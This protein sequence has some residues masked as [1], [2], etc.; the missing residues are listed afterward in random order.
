MFS[1]PW[2]MEW[3]YFNFP[4]TLRPPYLAKKPFFADQG[5][6]NRGFE[7]SGC[8]VMDPRREKNILLNMSSRRGRERKGCV[9]CGRLRGFFVFSSFSSSK[10][11]IEPA[12]YLQMLVKV[13]LPFLA[14]LVCTY[15]LNQERLRNKWIVQFSGPALNLTFNL[16]TKNVG[17][18]CSA[19]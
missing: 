8:N 18:W 3:E 5:S 10:V 4:S 14:L 2:S 13:L 19:E 12:L 9:E 16:Q 7:R 11:A 17:A 1:N 6:K 15:F